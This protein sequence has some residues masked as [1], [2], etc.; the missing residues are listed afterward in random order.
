M[1]FEQIQMQRLN[2]I[3]M[4]LDLDEVADIKTKKIFNF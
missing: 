2:I 1:K 4:D 3:P